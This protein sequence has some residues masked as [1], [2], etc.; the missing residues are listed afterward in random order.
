MSI[1][2]DILNSVKESRPGFETAIERVRRLEEA[3]ERALNYITNTENSLG[4]TLESG[5]LLRAALPHSAHREEDE[6]GH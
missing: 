1:A 3:A 2:T 6:H 5:D 4:I